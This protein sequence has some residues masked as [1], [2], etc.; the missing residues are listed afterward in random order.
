ME[1]WYVQP[2]GKFRKS[3]VAYD[4]FLFGFLPRIF[5]GVVVPLAI[6]EC[7]NVKVDDSSIWQY[8]GVSGSRFYF[9][10]S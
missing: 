10:R 6:G 9:H 8:F 7:A 5:D 2:S 4:V 3:M 1:D